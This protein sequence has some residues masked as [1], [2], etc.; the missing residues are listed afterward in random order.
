MAGETVG[1][2][3]TEALQDAASRVSGLLRSVQ[4]PDAPVPGLNWTVSETAAHMVAELADYA[5]F[6]RGDPNL[7]RPAGPEDDRTAAQRNAAA[8]AAQLT[9]FAERDL[10][11]LAD[12]VVPAADDFIAAAEARTGESIL[13]TNGLFMT[14]PTMTAVLLG[15][16]LIH[17]FDV[18]RAAHLPWRISRTDALHVVAGIMAIVPDYIDPQRATGLHVSYELRMRGGGRYRMAVDDG[19]AA[20]TAPGPRADCWIS[21]DPVAFLLVG[22]GRTGQWTQIAHGKLIAGGRKPWLGLAFSQLIT[23]P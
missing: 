15:E 17:G 12:M 2:T 9:R 5:A 7:A 14:I 13:A 18:A 19:A 6:A 20:V 4:H 3:T 10:F 16:V 22:Y 1:A 23:A 8:N 21:A 11:R